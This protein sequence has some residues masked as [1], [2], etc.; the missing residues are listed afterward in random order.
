MDTAIFDIETTGLYA[1][2]GI[3]LCCCIKEYRQPGIKTIRADQ[4]PNW[5]K[6]RTNQLLITTR[7]YNELKNYDILVAHNGQYFDKA[8]INTL[9]MK[10]NFDAAIRWKKFVDPVLI[11][12]RYLRLGR[13]SL[14]Q[15]LDYF[16][17]PN[18]KSHVDGHIWMAASLNRDRK[19][20]D[21]IVA[22]CQ[23]DVRC[24]EPLYKKVKPLIERIDNRGSA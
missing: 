14:D 21:E 16:E 20:M 7:I 4:F 13:N 17:I 2:F 6:D 8:W 18:K 3:I 15:C 1:N 10:Y 23:E 22:H 12:R 19:A 9:S 11:S 5:N 24:L